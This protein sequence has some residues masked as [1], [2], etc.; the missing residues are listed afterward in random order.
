M[1][2]NWSEVNGEMPGFSGSC[3]LAVGEVAVPLVPF[4]PLPG[5]SGA[6]FSLAARSCPVVAGTSHGALSTAAKSDRS[7]L[8]SPVKVL[9]SA[10]STDL[11]R[12]PGRSP[13]RAME[14]ARNRWMVMVPSA[15]EEVWATVLLSD[16]S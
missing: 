1:V 15:F 10:T 11:S 7:T 12:V 16:S 4:A 3:E 8:G 6:S 9:G 2:A 14:S 13:S 5:S